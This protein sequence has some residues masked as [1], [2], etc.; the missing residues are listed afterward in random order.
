M[1]RNGFLDQT[2][3]FIVAWFRFDNHVFPLGAQ[4]SR[5]QENSGGEK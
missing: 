3:Y 5:H 4:S 2:R 1:P